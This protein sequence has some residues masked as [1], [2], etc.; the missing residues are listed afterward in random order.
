M[1]PKV[2]A[3]PLR[4]ACA[5]RLRSLAER[6]APAPS[7]AR[8]PLAPLVRVA[9]RWWYRNEIVPLEL[10]EDLPQDAHLHP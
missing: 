3:P 8:R 5:A 10:A 7:W 9:G 6:L 2:T 1:L 4:S